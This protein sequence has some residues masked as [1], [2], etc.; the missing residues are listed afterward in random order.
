MNKL[1]GIRCH[2][3]GCP[4]HAN[5]ELWLR[6]KDADA[7]IEHMPSMFPF[8]IPLGDPCPHQVKPAQN[9]SMNIYEIW[10][11]GK[12]HYTRPEGHPDIQEALDLIER[13]KRL[14]GATAYE[15]RLTKRCK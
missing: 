3:S 10:C 2:D 14:Y 6:R 12:L 5:C 8:D 1:H 11:N 15:V 9:S 4:E 13:T 7:N